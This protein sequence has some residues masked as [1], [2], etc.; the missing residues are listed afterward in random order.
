MKDASWLIAVIILC[1]WA[2]HEFH[3]GILKN[4]M[5]MFFGG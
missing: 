3:V 5:R 1:A 4:T 2:D